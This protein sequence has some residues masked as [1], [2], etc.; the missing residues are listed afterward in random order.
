MSGLIDEVLFARRCGSVMDMVVC[1]LMQ[2][3]SILLLN[4][5]TQALVVLLQWRSQV[6]A[7]KATLGLLVR[8][9]NWGFYNILA[10]MRDWGLNNRLGLTN[11]WCLNNVL[12]FSVSGVSLGRSSF[13]FIA[14]AWGWTNTD[15]LT[16]AGAGLLEDFLSVV[17]G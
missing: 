7:S 12:G 3:S 10:L 11:E 15:L 2:P 4:R 8:T 14:V 9:S 17:I 16:R 13:L 5:L 6:R 1:R